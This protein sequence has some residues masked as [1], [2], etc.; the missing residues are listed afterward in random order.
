VDSYL[1]LA[2]CY[3]RAGDEFRQISTLET[4][5][6]NEDLSKSLSADTKGRVYWEIGGGLL[7]DDYQVSYEKNTGRPRSDLY[8]SVVKYLTLAGV[9]DQAN[10][11]TYFF[12]GFAEAENAKDEASKPEIER[13]VRKRFQE[14]KLCINEY[15]NKVDKSLERD[16]DAEYHYWFGRALSSLGQRSAGKDE[17]EEG[18]K[19]LPLSSTQ[20]DRFLVR[21]AENEISTSGDN[22]KVFEYLSKV[23]NREASAEVMLLIGF[24]KWAEATQAQGKPEFAAKA[25]DAEL[26]TNTAAR[27]GAPMKKVHILLGTLYLM[28]SDYTRAEPHLKAWLEQEP[29]ESMAYDM[30][31]KDL[32]ALKKYDEERTYAQKWVAIDPINPDAHANLGTA[33]GRLEDFKNA[34]PELQ[35]AVELK[36][37][38]VEY[39]RKLG[40][41][42]WLLASTPDTSSDDSIAIN[43]R[44]LGAL[45]RGADLAKSDG[46]KEVEQ[47]ISEREADVWNSLAYAYAERRT[48]L[49]LAREYIE[50]ALVVKPSDP[51][52]LDT[53][54][55]VLTVREITSGTN[56]PHE[57]QLV[58]AQCERSLQSASTHLPADAVEAR[59]ELQYHLGV[60]ENELGKKQLAR[61]HYLAALE[62]NPNYA[63]AKQALA[64]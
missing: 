62:V 55:W 57:R 2:E 15:A 45:G 53:K 64:K 17:L 10:P 19:L 5:V 20:R 28:D 7:T 26:A 54:A 50:K 48:N 56:N 6:T 16:L 63:P 24:E 60:I 29:S 38:Q 39:Y 46:E 33:L 61:Q 37:D 21:L 59:A 22:Q 23:S 3:H 36:P 8:Q 44:A 27:M 58:F 52:M 1:A 30:T 34:V 43:E 13:D 31:V 14:G 42:L 47:N 35:R 40:L 9:Y 4:L 49:D 11:F 51:Y 25:R 32:E 41:T 18:L 12:L